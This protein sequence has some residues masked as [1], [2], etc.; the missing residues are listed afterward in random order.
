MEVLAHASRASLKLHHVD[1]SVELARA[2]LGWKGGFVHPVWTPFLS[3]FG[4]RFHM[5]Q[6]RLAFSS[7]G[8]ASKLTGAGGELTGGGLAAAADVIGLVGAADDLGLAAAGAD[9]T[10]G[11]NFSQ[12]LSSVASLS[13]NS[14]AA[15][16]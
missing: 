7:S 3:T 15:G 14:C 9:V 4:T 16:F 1:G 12:A 11:L 5:T 6:W 2:L 10:A 8:I 13:M